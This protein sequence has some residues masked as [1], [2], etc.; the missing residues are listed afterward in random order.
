[1]YTVDVDE[2]LTD[3]GGCTQTCNNIDGSY[4]CSC[5]DGYQLDS[6][7]HTC[8]GQCCMYSS[9]SWNQL[10]FIQILRNVLLVLTTAL[11]IVWNSMEDM[12]V[13]VL[14]DMN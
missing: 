4:Q 2:C 10:K 13:D 8:T 7:N 11:I 12:S 3:N 1:M 6:D 14:M 9:N 5:W